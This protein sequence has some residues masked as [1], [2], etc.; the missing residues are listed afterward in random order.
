MKVLGKNMIA[1][2]KCLTIDKCIENSAEIKAML[3]EGTPIFDVY[4]IC[5]DN[6]SHNLA[7]IVHT[8]EILK[9]SCSDRRLLVIG[10]ADGRNNA[11]RLLGDIMQQYLNAGGALENFKQFYNEGAAV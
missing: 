9:P 1:Y 8:L 5:L 3:A 2:A 6:Q 11:K 10:M 4:L 7:E